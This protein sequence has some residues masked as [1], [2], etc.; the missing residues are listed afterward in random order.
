MKYVKLVED[1]LNEGYDLQDRANKKGA[2]ADLGNK[3]W[4]KWTKNVPSGFEDVYVYYLDVMKNKNVKVLWAEPTARGYK[5][6]TKTLTRPA[7][8]T[9]VDI[10]DVPQKAIDAVNKK[11]N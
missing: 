3:L 5:V 7:E 4:F 1:T 9:S 8:Y 2:V 11:L 10:K 6:T